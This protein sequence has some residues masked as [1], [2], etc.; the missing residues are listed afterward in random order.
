MQNKTE[1]DVKLALCVGES[2]RVKI[3][4]SK[5]FS[6]F[7]TK[8]T[9]GDVALPLLD[10]VALLCLHFWNW[11]RLKM[12]IQLLPIKSAGYGYDVSN[13]Y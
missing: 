12:I 3:E 8:A 2:S 10:K 4:K 6:V 9:E 5:S 13:C 7:R 1:D 11:F